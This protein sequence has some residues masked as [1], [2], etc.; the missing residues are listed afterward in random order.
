MTFKEFI[1]C[2]Y[3]AADCEGFID[4]KSEA[5]QTVEEVVG[6]DFSLLSE[7]EIFALIQGMRIMYVMERES[8]RYFE[9]DED[10]EV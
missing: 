5:L 7:E 9:D 10:E 3:E 1:D 2:L 8:W 4:R 6:I